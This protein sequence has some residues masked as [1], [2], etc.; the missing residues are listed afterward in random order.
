MTIICIII[1]INLMSILFVCVRMCARIAFVFMFF[2]CNLKK[3]LKF[4]KVFIS[5][6]IHTRMRAH[7]A[8][9]MY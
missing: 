4:L 3:L 6:H 2:I 8:H 7:H 5:I 9:N 1:L